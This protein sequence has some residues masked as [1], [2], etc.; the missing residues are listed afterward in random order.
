MDTCL[1][2]KQFFTALKKNNHDMIGMFALFGVL[3]M[4]IGYSYC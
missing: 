1:I 2:I 4:I 3:L